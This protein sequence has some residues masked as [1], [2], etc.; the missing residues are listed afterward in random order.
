[1]KAVI[2]LELLK[3]EG[4]DSLTECIAIVVVELDGF[5]EHTGNLH[6]KFVIDLAGVLPL[7]CICHHSI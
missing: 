2:L 7:S 1:M 5:F 3:F 6:T 4:S